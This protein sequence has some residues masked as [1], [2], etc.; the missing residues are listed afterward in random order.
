MAAQ[1]RTTLKGYFNTDDQPTEANFADLIDSFWLVGGGDAFSGAWITTGVIDNARVNW[2][3][4]SAIGT[5]TPA[6]GTFSALTCSGDVVRI[7][8][9][10]TPASAG[11]TGV[12][13]QVAWDANYVYV[14]VATDTWK[15][16]ALSTW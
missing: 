11:A 6:A 9:A 14:C 5:G 10:K 1:P 4:P 12:Q 8:T 3:A 15:R 16:A 13:G 2:A 7:Q